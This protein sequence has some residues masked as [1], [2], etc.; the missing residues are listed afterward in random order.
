[1]CPWIM[2][3]VTWRAGRHNGSR[4]AAPAVF[5]GSRNFAWSIPSITIRSLC[6]A[7]SNDGFFASCMA[8][9]VRCSNFIPLCC[10]S[11]FLFCSNI[12]LLLYVLF[13]F[14]FYVQLFLYYLVLLYC[15]LSNCIIFYS[16]TCCP[17][18]YYT[19]LLH[20]M[21][22]VYVVFFYQMLL[23]FIAFAMLCM[24]NFI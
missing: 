4:S 2:T 17:L 16:I 8:T 12:V 13:Y 7:P 3:P 1:M 23:C 5:L 18:L 21:P 14:V 15:S 6:P 10:A 20:Y 24:R 11:V 19:M 9:L 22:F